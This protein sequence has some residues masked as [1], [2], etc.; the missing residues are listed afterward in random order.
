[1]L[2]RYKNLIHLQRLI[3][4]VFIFLLCLFAIVSS[5]DVG[6]MSLLVLIPIAMLIC[7]IEMIEKKRRTKNAKKS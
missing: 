7:Y 3:A 4:L 5:W 6:A 1:M 2:K